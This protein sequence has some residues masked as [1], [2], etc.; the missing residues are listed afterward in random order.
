MKKGFVLL[1]YGMICSL[2][3]QAQSVNSE[4]MFTDPV[5]LPK[6]VNSDSAEVYLL[7]S[8]DSATL[9]FVRQG[10]PDNKGIKENPYDQDIWMVNKNEDG[11]YSDARNFSHF[12]NKENNAVVGMSLDGNTIYLLNAYLKKKNTLEKGISFAH[13]KGNKWGD[14]QRLDIP[15]LK[16]S[17]D[18][19]GFY[20]NPQETVILISYEGKDSKG[21]ED[22]YVCT[23][24]N[25][26]TWSK[27]L[28]L[29]PTIN[30]KG[31]EIS[32]YLSEDNYTLFW[33]T[34][35][36]GG[37]G[38]ADI[39]ASFRTDDSWTSWS[40]PVNM[41]N[42][43]N[44][45]GFDAYFIMSQNDAWFASDRGGHDDI[46]HCE[47]IEPEP[48]VD[49][50]PE[51][52]EVVDVVNSPIDSVIPMLPKYVEVKLF[53]ARNSSYLERNAIQVIDSVVSLMKEHGHVV[54][55]IHSHA[56]KRASDSYNE[57]LTKRRAHRVMDYM[58]LKG[59]E[60]KRLTPNWYGKTKL[61]VDC[62]ECTEE[63]HRASRR[64][65][66]KLSRIE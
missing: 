13:K 9:F 53:F 8:R 15:D 23:K 39:F 14:P 44:S 56:D 37:E 21:M 66:I 11:S 59:I 16:I 12:N 29:G 1:L 48:E 38:D 46:Y 63:E 62:V 2:S 51:T 18:F 27:P 52:V 30:T 61:A 58:V 45:P 60:Q 33:S 36:R 57:W 64:T 50:I 5:L 26:G 55:E 31:Y 10:H 35:G 4:L 24:N 28:N 40:E 34:D 49:T 42:K 19:Y 41:G 43:I 17:G 7:F 47:A 54:A 3:V 32:P 65:V 25:D 6:N 20:V 22:L